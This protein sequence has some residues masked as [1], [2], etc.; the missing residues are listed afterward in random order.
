MPINFEQVVPI[1]QEGQIRELGSIFGWR[2]DLQD[3]MITIYKLALK[4]GL[5]LHFAPTLPAPET[6]RLTL[7]Q[8]ITVGAPVRVQFGR[9]DVG[10]VREML[11]MMEQEADTRQM[12]SWVGAVTLQQVERLSWRAKKIGNALYFADSNGALLVYQRVEQL[13]DL[14]NRLSSKKFF[15][16]SDAYPGRRADWAE[17]A[18][19][20]LDT[21]LAELEA[22]IVHDEAL[23]AQYRGQANS[24]DT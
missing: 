18:W 9:M 24:G 14:K 22:Y 17:N 2:G 21:Q 12:V 20:F 10:T 8:D 5:E 13:V 4:G 19:S 3:H 1:T 6:F 7:R 11:R 15:T 23:Y 16:T